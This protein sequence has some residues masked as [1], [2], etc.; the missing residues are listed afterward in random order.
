VTPDS[1]Y[2]EWI[3]GYDGYIKRLARAYWVPG[4]ELDDFVQD[5]YLTAL[6]TRYRGEPNEN[7]ERAYLKIIA[8]SRRRTFF[9]AKYGKKAQLV[10]AGDYEE[11]IS[12]HAFKGGQFERILLK[13]ALVELKD[14]APY[15]GRGNK[16]RAK[17]A[18]LMV[19]KATG[20]IEEF[21]SA[22]EGRRDRY[23][24]FQLRQHLA[25]EYSIAS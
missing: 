4:Y 2:N 11:L 10:V 5:I 25:E 16:D 12:R 17:A 14:P 18:R 24:V 9:R 20:V 8:R 19:Q 13:E 22:I 23:N 1:P 6:V 15:K 21:G 3:V 7:I